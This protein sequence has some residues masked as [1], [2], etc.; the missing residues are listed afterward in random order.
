ML[1]LD[2]RETRK[3]NAK[4]ESKGHNDGGGRA[5]IECGKTDGW[6]DGA[7][8]AVP[9]CTRKARMARRA[10]RISNLGLGPCDAGLRLSLDS[11]GRRAPWMVDS[12]YAWGGVHYAGD[13]M[14]LMDR[15]DSLVLGGRRYNPTYS[16]TLLFLSRSFFKL[17]LFVSSCAEE[18]KV[19][20]MLDTSFRC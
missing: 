2:K 11:H 17:Y 7:F 1:Q 6:L 16:R 3:A 10:L 14:G 4:P 20:S 13:S 9:A 5:Q 12:G 19:W 18:K 15:L 8:K